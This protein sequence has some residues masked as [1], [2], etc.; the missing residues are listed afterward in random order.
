MGP[1]PSNPYPEV[2]EA[3]ARPVL[4]HLDPEFIS[5]LD[6]TNDRLREVWQTKN[7][8]TFP[9]SAT[10]SAG[11]ETSFVNFISPGDEV[12]VGVNGVFGNRMCDVASRAGAVVT[13]VEEE[14][15]RAIDPERLLAAHPNPKM[16]AVV[17]AETSTGVR[18]DIHDLG[19]GK[20]DA[21]LLVDCVTSLGGIPVLID[22]WAVDIAYSGTQKCLGV[23]PG[24]SPVTVSD[25]AMERLVETPQSWYLDLNMIKDYVTG[26]GARAYHHTAPISMLY[27]LHAGLGVVIDEGLQQAWERHQSCG[28]ELHRCLPELGFELWA[29]EG[30]R[31]PELTTVSI[32]DGLD[33]VEG[34]RHLLNRYGIE[35]GGGLGPVAGKVWRIG[36][37]GH[38][39][40]MR[41]VKMLLGA[42]E[43]LTAHLR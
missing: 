38:T 13:K 19:A 17:H 39:A 16:I 9:I 11:M 35:V 41:N 29:Q 37:M 31:L 43:E 30:H 25:R 14:W 27:A 12:V 36:C 24:L 2:M 26:D 28:D 6:E 42:L 34:R 22:E 10:G 7:A 8:L 40:Q 15:G 4:G 23:P 20:G 32:P 1:G 18:N 33:D 3:F 21:L 5:L